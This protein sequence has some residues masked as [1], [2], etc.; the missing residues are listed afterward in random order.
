MVCFLQN[1]LNFSP[2]NLDNSKSWLH[3]HNSLVN[4]HLCGLNTL[5]DFSA[6]AEESLFCLFGMFNF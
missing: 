4:N 5:R 6:W 1:N 3:I 2:Q